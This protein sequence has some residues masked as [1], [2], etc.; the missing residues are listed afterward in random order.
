[1]AIAFIAWLV[2]SPVFTNGPVGLQAHE[3]NRDDAI[4][5]AEAA[6]LRNGCTDLLPIKDRP[7][8]GADQSKVDFKFLISHELTCPATFA[9]EGNVN[10]KAAWIVGFGLRHTYPEMRNDSRD[11]LI[12]MNKDGSELRIENRRNRI[13]RILKDNR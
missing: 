7:K 2:L 6:I 12:L 10:G 8:L 5:A 13:K 9:L 1:M 11:R 3:L 4:A